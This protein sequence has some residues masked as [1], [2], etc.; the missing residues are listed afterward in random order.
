MGRGDGGVFS[1]PVT[2]EVLWLLRAPLSRDASPKLLNLLPAV[3]LPE[4]R[5]EKKLSGTNVTK[6]CDF[7]SVILLY[8]TF[9]RLELFTS[10]DLSPLLGLLL[11]TEKKVSN[12]NI[13]MRLDH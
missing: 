2:E 10:R 1:P 6:M 11:I 12:I 3:R 9:M 7:K 5:Q 13:N 4:H 8:D